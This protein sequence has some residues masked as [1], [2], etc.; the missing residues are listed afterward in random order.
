MLPTVIAFHG[1]ILPFMN[2]AKMLRRD[3]GDPEFVDHYFQGNDVEKAIRFC[4]Q[5]ERVFLIGYSK[6]GS[7]IGTLTHYLCKTRIAGA[8]L[9]ESPL[10]EVSSIPTSLP[11]DDFPVWSLWNASS[12][13]K[14]S[15]EGRDTVYQWERNR[16]KF[17]YIPGLHGKGHLQ[18]FPPAHSWDK[19]INKH[20]QD[21]INS[22]S[23]L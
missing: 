4:S 15:R 11:S 3:M 20:I 9:Y 14:D 1:S 13:R 18:W 7:T 21:W 8:V 12:S 2:G 10:L 17:T 16:S 19:G 6:G 22:T 5:F 23:I